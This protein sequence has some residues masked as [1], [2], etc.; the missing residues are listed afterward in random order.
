MGHRYPRARRAARR[1]SP[2]AARDRHR[3]L[4]DR[5]AGDMSSAAAPSRELLRQQQLLRALWRRGSDAPLAPWLREGGERA[6]N[7]LAAYRGNAA[8]IAERTLAT[9]YPTVQQ[10]VGTESF[11]Q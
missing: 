8:A 10:L 6:T 5:G 4:G 3:G 7:G 2:R 11:A 1:G 9:A